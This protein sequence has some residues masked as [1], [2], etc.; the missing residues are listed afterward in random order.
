MSG[1]D[2]APIP[3]D[4]RTAVA[5]RRGRLA[6]LGVVCAL[7][8]SIGLAWLI[9]S[10]TP[11]PRP[12]PPAR[13]AI[14]LAQVHAAAAPDAGQ[15]QQAFEAVQDAYADRGVDGLARAD[16]DC[17]AAL[18]A[19]PRRLDY[20]LA[21][22]LFATAV[23]PE[24]AR[25]DPEGARLEAARAALPAGVDPVQHMAAL[26]QMMR[27]A[28]LGAPPPSAAV[29]EG[30]P[31]ARARPPH[32]SRPRGASEKTPAAPEAQRRQAARSAVQDLFSRAEGT[33]GAAKGPPPPPPPPESSSAERAR[34]APH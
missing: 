26:R 30:P 2:Q 15:V 3:D 6:I 31:P 14:R 12:S 34:E 1:N 18:K 21:F 20:C 17:A 22:D 13:P 33:R 7:V 16:A 9:G 5:A 28:S 4:P 25:A 24:I 11:T 19:D 10:R 29:A 32:A 27:T 8:V 23:A